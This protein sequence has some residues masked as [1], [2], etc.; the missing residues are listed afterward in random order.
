[1]K[2][3][4]KFQHRR[5]QGRDSTTFTEL[6]H[7]GQLNLLKPEKF[8]TLH[9]EIFASMGYGGSALGIML[10]RLP[11]KKITTPD[12]TWTWELEDAKD[13]IVTA[14]RS[15][16]DV[17]AG[18]TKPGL[19][20]TTFTIALN[21][22]RFLYGETLDCGS[23]NKKYQVRIQS[24][25]RNV[26]PNE[27]HYDVRLMTDDKTLFL[28]IQFQSAGIKWMKLAAKYGEGAERSGGMTGYDKIDM[29]GCA[30]RLRKKYEV[31]GDAVDA[32]LDIAI[33]AGDGSV[34]RT[35]VSAAEAQFHWEWFREKDFDMYYSR[36]TG[37]FV[38]DSTGRPVKSGYGLQQQMELA[39]SQ[40]YSG[41][42]STRLIE[43]YLMDIYYGRV[44]PG[45]GRD[46]VILTG[47]VGMRDFSN[48][49][50]ERLRAKGYVIQVDS[51]I[52]S[53]GIGV[54]GSTEGPSANN[55]AFGYQ[56]VKYHMVN[57][58]TVTVVH[59]PMYDDINLHT[60]INPRTG[61]PFESGRMTFLD[62]NSEVGSPNI[63]LVEREGA[64]RGAYIEGLATKS[65]GK[66]SSGA[67]KA[68]ISTA[69][70]SGDYYE[71]HCQDDCGIHMED[72]SRCGELIPAEAF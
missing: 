33:R 4:N 38:P 56:F 5:V 32:T 30:S 37:G 70:H 34:H 60:Q 19:N 39:N 47:E 22:G 23:L 58:G 11:K 49:V 69:S 27:F 53:G 29:H 6:N 41:T 43:E 51:N 46:T 12:L 26:G 64:F 9:R 25:V 28:P 59:E 44:K 45:K 14:V 15:V 8:S 54:L 63:Q 55:L 61:L 48:A 20:G 31:T 35:W 42:I 68:L 16:S 24:D 50:E 13:R 1:M 40:G 17:N 2:F 36:Y 52:G 67:P 62:F 57:G 71:Y 21:S 66:G 65:G 3:N 7:L 10:N 72:P 18:I